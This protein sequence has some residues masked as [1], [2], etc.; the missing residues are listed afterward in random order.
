MM[1]DTSGNGAID[2]Q[3]GF[4]ALYCATEAEIFTRKEAEFLFNFF[5]AHANDDEDG[6]EG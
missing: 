2:A 6:I 3:E 4:N 5:G 1:M